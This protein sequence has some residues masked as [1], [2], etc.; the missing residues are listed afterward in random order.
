MGCVC[1]PRRITVVLLALSAAACEH[2]ELSFL[3]HPFGLGKE[4]VGYH[5]QLIAEEAAPEIPVVVSL[6]SI[7]A[8]ISWS[9][10]AFNELSQWLMLALE[11]KTEHIVIVHWDRSALVDSQGKSHGIFRSEPLAPESISPGNTVFERV[12]PADHVGKF[13]GFPSCEDW[14]LKYLGREAPLSVVL[15]LEVGSRE[16]TQSYRFKMKLT[17]VE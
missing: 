15:A 8:P 2:G 4:P 6:Q 13:Q 12:C 14:M 11:N 5:A 3:S 9:P 1:N 10:R 16:V 7:G 17:E